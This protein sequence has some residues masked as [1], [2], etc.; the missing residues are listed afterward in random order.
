MVMK[1]SKMY[2]FIMVYIWYHK[3]HIN[4]IVNNSE[5]IDIDNPADLGYDTFPDSIY[6]MNHINCHD[7]NIGVDNRL[8][9]NELMKNMNSRTN[10]LQKRNYQMQLC[11]DFNTKSF[12]K[13]SAMGFFI[14]N[15]HSESFANSFLNEIY[16]KD[17]LTQ[18]QS[19]FAKNFTLHFY[20]K[21]NKQHKN[22]IQDL[23]SQ[24]FR[25]H[26]DVLNYQ[27]DI[28]YF[29]DLG[30]KRFLI[31]DLVSMTKYVFLI[32]LFFVITLIICYFYFI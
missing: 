30:D 27:N 28:F 17:T 12:L 26:V 19:H 25:G 2:Y 9:C 11:H 8:I 3:K 1:D 18:N 31:K 10:F 20:E 21:K 24:A 15:K 29:I 13:G 22:G 32:W 5:T 23:I 16:I 4:Q 14:D 7:L 6:M